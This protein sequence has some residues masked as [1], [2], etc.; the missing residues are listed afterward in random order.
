MTP[1][2]LK[3]SAKDL[4]KEHFS[5]FFLPFLPY[6]VLYFLEAATE[7]AGNEFGMNYGGA[8]NSPWS[9][10]D[11]SNIIIMIVAVTFIFGICFVCIDSFRG[12]IT[13]DSPL[14]KSFTL[15]SNAK[16]FWGTIFIKSLDLV[17]LAKRAKQKT[18][19]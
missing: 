2:E 19:C 3:K 14:A 4:L 11:T 12:K 15:F 13:Y 17:E 18:T 10:W 8:T 9:I 7:Y 5:F 6:L 16:Y 1:T